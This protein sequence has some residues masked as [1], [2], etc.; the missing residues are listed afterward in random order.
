MTGFLASVMN[1][2]EAQIAL[3]Y[4]ADIIDLKNP[5]AGALGALP[6]DTVSEV[7][8]LVGGRKLV[9]ATVG[10]LPMTPQILVS[11]VQAMATTGVNVVKI[12]LYDGG[13][14][15]HCLQQLGEVSRETRLVLVI[16]A[17]MAWDRALLPRLANCGFYGVMLDTARKNG[18]SLTDHLDLKQLANFVT[19]A[20]NAGLV[21]GLAGSL[22]ADDIDLLG[23]LGASYLGFRGA[24]CSKSIR[25]N[26]LQAEKVKQ[27]YGLLHAGNSKGEMP[28]EIALQP[29]LALQSA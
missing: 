27:I 2:E 14:L 26:G 11:A 24:L 19:E 4:G 29:A 22:K 3:D 28:H 9:S 12:G 16:F 7:V 6:L 17:D 1:T 18:Q 13:N 10:D 15:W 5:L 25:I 20:R 23:R 8:K 21:T